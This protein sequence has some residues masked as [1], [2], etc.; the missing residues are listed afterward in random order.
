[1]P[2]TTGIDLLFY[3]QIAKGILHTFRHIQRHHLAC[4]LINL[5]DIPPYRLVGGIT[6]FFTEFAQLGV[7]G[8]EV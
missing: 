3:V 1:M 6:G 5:F 2:L 4:P 7:I 8:V